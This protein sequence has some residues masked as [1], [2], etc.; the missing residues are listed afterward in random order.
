M[1]QKEM[2]TSSKKKNWSYIKEKVLQG[3]KGQGISHTLIC[4]N[5]LLPKLKKT[6]G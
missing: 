3:V 6:Q 2:G 5:L 4:R 1:G